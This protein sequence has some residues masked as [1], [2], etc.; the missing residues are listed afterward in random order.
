M[1]TTMLLGLL[2]VGAILF[3]T[4]TIHET[5]QKLAP[6]TSLASFNYLLNQQLGNSLVDLFD[7]MAME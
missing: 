3:S 6:S 1:I 7:E 4:I 5:T 2:M